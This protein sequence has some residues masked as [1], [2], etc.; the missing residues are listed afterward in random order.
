M[1]GSK[2]TLTGTLT[3][4]ANCAALNDTSA[5]PTPTACLPNSRYLGPSPVFIL[6]S[7][8]AEDIEFDGLKLKLE[9]VDPNN[10]FW[11]FPKVT[12][13][14]N[15]IFKATDPNFPN[16][17]TGNF[18]G[19]MPASVAV[20]EANSTDLTI[21]D[22]NTSFRGVRFLGF[23]S[24]TTSINSSVVMAALTSVDQPELIPV[25]QLQ[26]PNRTDSD[27]TRFVDNLQPLLY[28][29]SNNR[30]DS[31]ING[32]PKANQGQWT[33]R[34]VRSEVNAYFVAGMTPSR[35]GMSYKTSLTA[36]T[37]S[38]VSYDGSNN[39]IPNPSAGN[40]SQTDLGETGGGLANFIR[41]LENWEA[42]P[43]KITG[44]FLQ[45]TRSVFS[46]AP[47]ASTAPFVSNPG[48]SDIQ[49]LYV[50]PVSPNLRMSGYNL[51]YQS[52]AS[53]RIPYYTPPI[54]LWGYD[55]GLLTQQPDRF[56]ERFATPIPGANEF[57][58]E[59]S[60]DDPWVEAL[61]CAL[62]PANPE[63]VNDN[64]STVNIGSPQKFGTSPTNYTNRSLRGADLPSK[65]TTTIYGG[66]TV[67]YD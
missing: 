27:Q 18:M 20:S 24:L 28:D 19:T 4:R 11:I 51:V 35:N 57:F 34:P 48:F 17:V 29:A 50:N 13:A 12:G 16:V 8:A 62:E 46:T 15:V 39:T 44:G 55:V 66:A 58:R 40:A 21:S 52:V 7:D 38:S 37:S 60:G 2:R 22:R 30:K 61:L 64:T 54:R 42:V 65:C 43:L 31:G 59:V 45:N 6:R 53:Q 5:T 10:V 63:T 9:G 33:M 41:L 3:L 23:R 49:T 14:D 25:L 1:T 26:F 36:S 47:F 32:V 67:S 56:A